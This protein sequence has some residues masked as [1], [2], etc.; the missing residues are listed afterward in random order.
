LEVL[1]RGGDLNPRTLAGWR[2]SK[3]LH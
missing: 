3:P 2:F 1:R